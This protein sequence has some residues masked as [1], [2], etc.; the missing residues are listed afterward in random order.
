MFERDCPHYMALGMTYEQYWYGDPLAVRYF[1]EADRIKAERINYEAWLNGLYT[2]KALEATVG[3]IFKKKGS[4]PIEYPSKPF[5]FSDSEKNR[6]EHEKELMREK[7]RLRLVAR[8]NQVRDARKAAE[9][10]KSG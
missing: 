9:V 8:L 2:C 5:E 1:Y 6:T 10:R 7:E 4:K 3:N